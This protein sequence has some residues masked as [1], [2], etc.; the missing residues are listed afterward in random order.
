MKLEEKLAKLESMA[1]QIEQETSLEKSMK[2]FAESV[3]LASECMEILNDCK[4]QLVVLQDK[5]KE[6]NDVDD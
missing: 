5:M 2:I 1:D 4:G 3:S 6:L